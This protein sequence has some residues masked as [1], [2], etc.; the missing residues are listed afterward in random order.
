MKKKLYIFQN[1][2]Y[3]KNVRI[4]GGDIRLINI[5]KKI[6]NRIDQNSY[7]FVS[8]EGYEF[9]RKRNLK[10][11]FCLSPLF[12]DYLGIY[13]CYLLRT[14]WVIFKLLF[15]DKKGIV[16]Y[17]S[18]DFFPDTLAPFLFKTRNNTW[19]QV[20]HHL[21]LPPSKR[22]GNK[23]R[24]LIGYISQKL[25]LFLIR[26][27]ADKVIIVDPLL[28]NIL[29]SLGFDEEKIIVSSNG[30]N[31]DYFK[32]LEE[33]EKNFEA[34]FLGRLTPAKG[35]FDLIS[36]W[37]KVVDE[38]PDAKL[39]VIG[40]SDID[41][42][43]KMEES[44]VAN[45]LK[46]NIELAGYQEDDVVFKMLKG[47]KL[48]I[49]PSHEEGWG[50]AIA[51][52]MASGLLPICWDLAKYKTIFEDNIV[53]VSEGDIDLFSQKVLFYLKENDRRQQEAVCA[54][55]FIDKYDWAKVAE[56]EWSRIF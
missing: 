42:R 29:V 12:F 28:K 38:K 49:F 44:I 41:V 16:L 13:L 39:L 50:I 37:R 1:S 9:D 48:F 15:K 20:I 7:I 54:Y 4:S 31:F 43:K 19:V 46:G 22:E 47:S 14:I 8:K 18:S 3:A 30:I 17:S 24:N 45:K 56:D 55:E 53:R 27:K 2:F 21:Y 35:A 33:E 6:S 34:S 26:L 40:G 23:F 25:S 10:L 51:E 11:N 36:I 52:A 32:N 5:L